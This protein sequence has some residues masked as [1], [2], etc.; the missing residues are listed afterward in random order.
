LECG[1][2]FSPAQ[3]KAK[4]SSCRC[5]EAVARW[6][7]SM[8]GQ[9]D[10]ASRVGER[11]LKVLGINNDWLAS[12]LCLDQDDGLH[13]LQTEATC[14]RAGGYL[15]HTEKR[16]CPIV[17]VNPDGWQIFYTTEL[18]KEV[19]WDGKRADPINATTTRTTGG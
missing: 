2:I 3:E 16:N 1:D 15:F 13:R 11:S 19:P 8:T 10:V 6:R 7:N 17:M 14:N 12:V 5:G 4:P 9:L 18:L